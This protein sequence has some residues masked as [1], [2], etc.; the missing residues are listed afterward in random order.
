MEV[1]ILGAVAGMAFGAYTVAI[2]VAMGQRRDAAAGGAIASI[3]AFLI[4]LAVAVAAGD[5]GALADDPAALLPFAAHRGRR[6][7][8]LA[9][10]LRQRRHG[11][12]PVA[13]RGRRRHGAAPRPP[14]S[15]VVALGEPW[16]PALAVG[17][18]L[19]VLGGAS[20]AWER[21]RPAGFAAYGIALAA[22]CAVLFAIRDN[23]V[24][25]QAAGSDVPA[26]VGT[27][28]SLFGA[29]VALTAAVVVTR[30]ARAVERLRAATRPFLLCAAV[31]GFAYACLFIALDRGKVTVVAPLN[32]TQSL[33]AVAFAAV[34]LRQHEKIGPRLLVAA[35]LIVAGSALV[36]ATR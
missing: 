8:P 33:W 24:R 5:G 7:G 22:L 10:G 13:G 3:G 34:F 14:R 32:A 19:V 29:A 30:P 6:A 11:G 27:A 28:A 1:V 9:A 17:T 23:V 26:L 25:D 35:A 2:R 16:R 12:R 31:L 18:V 21:E 36:A 4:V 15:A 20:L